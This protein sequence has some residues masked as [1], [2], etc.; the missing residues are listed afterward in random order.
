MDT[1]S[2]AGRTSS[3][4]E[5][6]EGICVMPD[7]SNIK[8]EHPG[9]SVDD[10]GA[11]NV[12]M[13]IKF[14]LPNRFDMNVCSRF[15]KS[16]N[17]EDSKNIQDQVNSDLEVASVLFKAE[18][19][20]Q[21]SPSPGIQ[22]RHVYTPSTT[23]HFSPI[24]QS[25]TLTNKHRGN[26]VSSTPLLVHSLSIHQLAAQ[27]EMVFLASRIEQG[28]NVPHE[29]VINLQDEEGFTPLMWAAAHGQ[30][31]VVEFLLQN[32]A[33]PNLLAK[34]RESA[35]SLAC[36]KGY[37]DI[38]KMLI[39]CGVDVNE[40]DWNGGV[41]V[42]YAVHGNHLRCVEILLESGADPTIESDSGFNAMDMAVAMGHRNVQ[43]VMEA[44][45]LKLLMG[46]RE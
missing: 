30:I 4:S 13:G 39:D 9:G 21:T 25:T 2:V 3:V 19:N 10:T 14:I 7:M 8:S 31:A 33:D 24:K 28:G 40:Y 27:G 43:Q 17:E 46:I 16:L 6:M 38:V 23:K 37:T 18:C 32:G 29:T 26:E 15:V 5:E 36:S 41:P 45:L 20:I 34:G 44:H 11:Q 22:V 35:L 12:A 42:L 1:G